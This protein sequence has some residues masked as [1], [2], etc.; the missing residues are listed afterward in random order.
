MAEKDPQRDFEAILRNPMPGPFIQYH[1]LH[2]PRDEDHELIGR[3]PFRSCLGVIVPLEGRVYR[4]VGRLLPA[5]RQARLRPQEYAQD[6]RVV[7]RLPDQFRGY[8]HLSAPP[9]VFS[10]PLSP[11][12]GAVTRHWRSQKSA[13]TPRLT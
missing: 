12:L 2:R 5:R 3:K 4:Y 7:V 13:R 6:P 10:A 11:P 1:R 9:R 8:A